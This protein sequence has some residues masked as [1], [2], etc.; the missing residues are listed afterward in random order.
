[1]IKVKDKVK[2]IVGRPI[3]RNNKE[4]DAVVISLNWSMFVRGV[5]EASVKVIIIIILT[6]DYVKNIS[7]I[8]N[9]KEKNV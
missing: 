8:P 6:I 1:M 9:F 4:T 7:M 5:S 2:E 3:K